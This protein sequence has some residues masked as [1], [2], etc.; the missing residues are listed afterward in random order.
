M[1]FNKNTLLL[2]ILSST[3]SIASKW[4]SNPHLE[5]VFKL[6]TEDWG[7]DSH[8]YTFSIDPAKETKIKFPG[9]ILGNPAGGGASA[10]WTFTNKSI[11]PIR[12]TWNNLV[13]G[14]KLAKTFT[15]NPNE[16][17]ESSAYAS[18]WPFKVDLSLQGDDTTLT[19]ENIGG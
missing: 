7:T 8:A 11:F 6:Y 4:Q 19:V 13:A 5:F 16:T 18:N 17:N 2:L 10:T 12:L 15:L 1:K 9:S 3:F 14:T